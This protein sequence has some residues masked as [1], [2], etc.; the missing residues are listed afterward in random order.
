MFFGGEVLKVFVSASSRKEDEEYLE[1][2]QDIAKVL[3]NKNI[4][5]ATGG[6]SSG[7]MRQVYLEF[8]SK[9][10]HT[11]V[12]TLEVYKEDLADVDEV[13]LMDN[14]FDRCK[15]IYNM[16]DFALFLP[17]GTGSLSEL[18]AMI[19]EART[20]KDKP[21]ILYNANGCFNKILDILNDYIK[22][23][24]NDKKILDKICVVSNLNELD[25]KIDKIMRQKEKKL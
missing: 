10:K 17:G 18:L 4:D 1:M 9:K 24:F 23:G 5:L 19:E 20:L 22:F 6:I 25:E 7:M 2:S 3:A 21:L 11:I 13:Y 16:M 15:K 8:K 14:T 12:V